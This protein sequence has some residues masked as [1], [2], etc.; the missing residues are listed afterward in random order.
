MG[1]GWCC[2]GGRFI[3]QPAVSLPCSAHFVPLIYLCVSALVPPLRPRKPSIT[4]SNT[5]QIAHFCPSSSFLLTLMWDLVVSSMAHP[6]QLRTASRS[7]RGKIRAVTMAV[8]EDNGPTSSSCHREGRT[9]SPGLCPFLCPRSLQLSSSLSD[10]VSDPNSW[11][12][13]CL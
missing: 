7:C 2:G 12:I 13:C 4:E 6:Q 11:S 9:S 5:V 1:C 3:F 10:Q 8:D